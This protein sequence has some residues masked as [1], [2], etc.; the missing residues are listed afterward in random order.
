[1]QATSPIFA[2]VYDE[3]KKHNYVS[4][5]SEIPVAKLNWLV[6]VLAK[7]K[8]LPSTVDLSAQIDQ[9]VNADALK[10]SRR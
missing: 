10:L 1:M 3:A 5:T 7:A 8:K 6:G 9:S 4:P 2:A